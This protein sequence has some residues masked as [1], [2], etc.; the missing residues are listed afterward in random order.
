[1]IILYVAREVGDGP[2]RPTRASKRPR[3]MLASLFAVAF[4]ALATD[5]DPSTT[6]GCP[7][8]RPV[9]DGCGRP[10]TVADGLRRSRS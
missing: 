8:R 3:S 1:L 6:P 5:R 7:H 2:I 4:A 9:G 10:T